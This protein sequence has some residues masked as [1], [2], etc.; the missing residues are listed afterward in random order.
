MPSVAARPQRWPTPVSE[1][2][3]VA[4]ALFVLLQGFG[5]V[6]ISRVSEL[7]MASILESALHGRFFG[8]PC[9][10]LHKGP[11]CTFVYYTA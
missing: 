10:F 8:F 6:G 9:Y 7:D 2:L 4:A 1:S 5:I 3:V 11:C